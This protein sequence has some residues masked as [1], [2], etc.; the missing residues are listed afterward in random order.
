VNQ[1]WDDAAFKHRIKELAQRRGMTVRQA[2]TDA[3]VSPYYLKKAV[4]GRSTNTVLK[5]ATVLDVPAAEM[6]GLTTAAPQPVP[7]EQPDID[8]EQLKR[9][10]VAARMMAAQL[11][12]L[13]YVASNGSKVDPMRLMQIVLREIDGTQHS[14][15]ERDGNSE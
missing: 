12:A 6:F 3:G 2:L 13:V 14:S 4:E 10:M 1:L 5:L 7:T 8:S 11:A 15:T 9:I